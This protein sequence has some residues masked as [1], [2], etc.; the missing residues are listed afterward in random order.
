MSAAT[1]K[2]LES[3]L[4]SMQEALKTLKE[5]KSQ[6]P[7]ISAFI[8]TLA[9]QVISMAA[10]LASMMSANEEARKMSC[11]LT[12]NLKKELRQNKDLLEDSIQSKLY[13]VRLF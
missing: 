5:S 3:G 4:K 10:S 2:E 9:P 11:T 8:L 7:Q 12:E 13:W 6:N 1:V